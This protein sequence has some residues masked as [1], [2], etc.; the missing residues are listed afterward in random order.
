[1]SKTQFT[2]VIALIALLLWSFGCAHVNYVGQ[3]FE[4][5]KEVDVYY[6]ESEIERDYMVVGHAISAGQLFVSVDKL[7][8]KLSEKAKSSGADAILI[9][10]I[11][12]DNE[13][14]GRG[15]DAEKQ[16]KASFL[17]YK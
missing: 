3:S 14:D 17:K 9:K 13:V 4:P 12:R 11:G 2:S 15:L 6:S 1:M 5:S 7:Q 16:I 8:R 10:G